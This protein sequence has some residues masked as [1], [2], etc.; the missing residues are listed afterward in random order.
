MI[1]RIDVILKCEASEI[2]SENHLSLS[3]IILFSGCLF[4]LL[5]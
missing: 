4:I 5:I 3:S 1:E 2:A